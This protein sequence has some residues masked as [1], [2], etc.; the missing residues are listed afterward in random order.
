MANLARVREGSIQVAKVQ[1]RIWLVQAVFWPLVAVGGVA[2]AVVI[3]RSVWRRG[4]ATPTG[5][6]PS[7][8]A[9]DPLPP[10]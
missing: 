3:A 9:V 2:I 4:R 10:R 7:P 5:G 1:R 8:P 6:I